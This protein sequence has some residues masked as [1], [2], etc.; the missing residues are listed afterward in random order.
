MSV[1]NGSVDAGCYTGHD[2][3]VDDRRPTP[4]GLTPAMDAGATI[5]L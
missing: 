1:D 2:A 4:N 5:S 3:P